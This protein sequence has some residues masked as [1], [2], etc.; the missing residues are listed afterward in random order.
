MKIEFPG[1]KKVDL[2]NIKTKFD[3]KTDLAMP[4]RKRP[5]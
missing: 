2:E 5:G 1:G 3:L 4:W